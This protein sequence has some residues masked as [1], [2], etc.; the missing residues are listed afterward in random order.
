MSPSTGVMLLSLGWFVTTGASAVERRMAIEQALVG[1][2]VADVMETDLPQVSPH[3][4]LDVFADRFMPDGL[5]TSL[6]VVADGQVVGVIGLDRVRRVGRRARATTRAEDIMAR[7]P[8]A[9]LLDG[10]RLLWDALDDLRRA[11]TD[12]LAVVAGDAGAALRGML[13]RRGATAAIRER[14]ARSSLGR[15]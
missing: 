9:P 6:P 3:L 8:A 12:G 7:P 13:T 1:V 10:E 4:T 14:L 5:A 2:R 11:G 15:A